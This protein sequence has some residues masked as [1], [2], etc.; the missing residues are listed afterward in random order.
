MKKETI[1]NFKEDGVLNIE[2]VIRTYNS[3]IY[4]V[5]RNGISNED[6]IE[7]I[8]GDI[9]TILWKNYERLD[10]ATEVKPYLIGIAK[11][12]IKKKYQE[13]NVKFEDIGLYED[14]FKCDVNLTEIVENKEK[15]Q[16]ISHSLDN[17]KNIDREIFI[18]FY[19]NQK[20]IKEIARSL[21]ITEAKVKIILH[22]TRK[23][24][25]KNLKERGYDYGK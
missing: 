3:Y 21:K 23:N 4:K 19:Y 6:D 10:N 1:E 17:M 13:Y 9:F 5:L 16:I 15:A 22:R 12:L 7:E 25:K 2:K 24:M 14:K 20:K 11:N 18:M 8:L